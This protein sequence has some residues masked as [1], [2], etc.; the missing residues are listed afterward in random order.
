M[1]LQVI[2]QVIQEIIQVIQ[3]FGRKFVQNCLILKRFAILFNVLLR[4]SLP[5]S[6]V[7]PRD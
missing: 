4:K 6:V 2:I 3:D 1:N 5:W 7:T